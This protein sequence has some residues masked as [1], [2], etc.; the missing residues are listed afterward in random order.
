M[1]SKGQI[2]YKGEEKINVKIERE[3]KKT[4]ILKYS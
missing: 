3:K 2:D 4:K 1:N